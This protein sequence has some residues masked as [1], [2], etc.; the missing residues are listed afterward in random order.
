MGRRR[1]EL[2]PVPFRCEI[3]TGA[4][5]QHNRKAKANVAV[6]SITAAFYVK[7]EEAGLERAISS[8]LDFVDE[9]IIWDTGSTDGTLAIAEKYANR[10]YRLKVP[11]SAI[12]F[13]EMETI[14]THL[15][16]T[17][18]V[19]RLDGDETLTNGRLLRELAE[20]ED[21]GVWKLPRRRW[22]DLAMTA[23]LEQEA[24]PDWQYRFMYADGQSC[25][26]DPLHPKFETPHVIGETR[27]VI[28][29]HFVDPLHLN[30]PTRVRRRSRLYRRLARLSGKAPEG[31]D[32][33]M[34]LAGYRSE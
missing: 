6:T 32:E 5:S 18:W 10:I 17:D 33:A 14:V 23:Q 11:F 15:A 13:G 31:S 7:N 9:I 34:R 8:V 12:D 3:D 1:P 21:Y 20:S 24:W 4:T 27:D 19:L 28:I 2:P 22:A 30:D 26:V 25:Y 29:E 16:K